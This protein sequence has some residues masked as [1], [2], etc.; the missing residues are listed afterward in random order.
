[1]KK[2]QKF[3][4]SD[5]I[6]FLKEQGER[7]PTSNPIE[8]NMGG[9]LPQFLANKILKNINIPKNEKIIAK[10]EA[11]VGWSFLDTK[12]ENITDEIP[13]ILLVDSNGIEGCLKMTSS[14]TVQEQGYRGNIETWS[15]IFG[16][17]KTRNIKN[18]EFFFTKEEFKKDK[19]VYQPFVVIDDIDDDSFISKIMQKG[20]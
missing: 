2:P 19:I 8:I 17:Y 16:N 11:Y 1:M 4:E 6:Y 13:D 14:V 15:F 7:I 3:K 20:K 12:G 18:N 10:D 5:K 9:N